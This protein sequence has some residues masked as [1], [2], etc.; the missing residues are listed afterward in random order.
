M[1][2]M[3]Y[4]NEAKLPMHELGFICSL[5]QALAEETDIQANDLGSLIHGQVKI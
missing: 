4:T 1:N 3:N 5:T 2:Y